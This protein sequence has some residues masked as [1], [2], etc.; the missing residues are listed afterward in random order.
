[1]LLSVFLLPG[2]N[3]QQPVLLLVSKDLHDILLKT[4]RE[5]VFIGASSKDRCPEG[6]Y[7]GSPSNNR[8]IK[9]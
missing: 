1:M 5:A 7:K 8:C 4:Q 3:R 9:K 6:L 2:K